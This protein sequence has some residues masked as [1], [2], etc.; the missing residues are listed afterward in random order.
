MKDIPM[1][2]THASLMRM[3]RNSSETRRAHLQEERQAMLQN[4]SFQDALQAFAEG[5]QSTG[6]KVAEQAYSVFS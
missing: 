1:I 4:T 6:T 2:C 3:M 5:G